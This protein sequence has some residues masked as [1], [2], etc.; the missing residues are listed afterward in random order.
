MISADSEFLI[1]QI[2][3]EN[4]TQHKTQ[5]S[6]HQITIE[7]KDKNPSANNVELT[8]SRLSLAFISI[9]IPKSSIKTANAVQSL[10]RLSHSNINASLLGAHID[11]N[12]ARTATGSV[13][14]INIQNS[15]QTSKGT[16]SQTSGK[17]KYI[18]QPMIQAASKSPKTAR[19][20]MIFQFC[21]S[22][23]YFILYADS[24]SNTGKNT[25]N[26]ISGVNWNAFINENKSILDKGTKI[27]QTITSITV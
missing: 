4:I 17:T 21:K 16:S 10:K 15:K 1:F 22:S 5:N 14:D 24:K 25:K 3:F 13:A 26:R 23:L 20:N 18:S 27:N 8:T 12:N 2:I 19:V 9:I 11:L 6:I 7:A